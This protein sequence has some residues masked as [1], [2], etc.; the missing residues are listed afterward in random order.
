[1]LNVKRDINNERKIFFFTSMAYTLTTAML[2]LSPT[3]MI[4]HR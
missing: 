3:P 2:S 1:M 4:E